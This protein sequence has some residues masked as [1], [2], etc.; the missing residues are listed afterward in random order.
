MLPNGYHT[1]LSGDGS[2]LSQV[3]HQL[4]SIVHA[5]V[6]NPQVMIL[7]ASTSSI[8]TR[9]EAI[10]QKGKCYQIYKGAFELE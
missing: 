2:S 9:T 4:I 3:Q 1:L 5:A 10:V 6:A 7:D 8:D